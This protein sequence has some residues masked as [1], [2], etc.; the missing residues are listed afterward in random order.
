MVKEDNQIFVDSNF[1][2]ALFNLTDSLHP[3]VLKI[4]RGLKRE[5][6]RLYISNFIFLE[7]VTVLSQRVNRETAVLLGNYL[8]KDKQLEVIH[9]DKKLNEIT[10]EIFKSINKKNCSFVDASILAVMKREGIKKLLTFD[11]E[12][13]LSLKRKYRFNLYPT[14]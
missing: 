3:K 10:W 12:D 11:K 6:P 14:A 4:S 1:F 9:I 2:I 7:I 8:L 13:F 5:N